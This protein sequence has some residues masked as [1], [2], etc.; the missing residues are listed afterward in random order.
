MKQFEVE[1]KG[2]QIDLL[3]E[4]VAAKD[5]VVVQLTNKVSVDT[6]T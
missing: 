1:E 2:E 4:T 5:H 3:T 6:R